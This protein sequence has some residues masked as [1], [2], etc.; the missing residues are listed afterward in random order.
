MKRKQLIFL[1]TGLIGGLICVSFVW[2]GSPWLMI[3]GLTYGVGPLFFVALI[4]GILITGAHRYLRADLLHYLAGLVLCTI[5]Y[6]LAL[7]AFFAVVGISQKVPGVTPSER[8]YNFGL[9][10]WLGLLCAGAVGAIGIS[11][12]NALLT[13]KWSNVL[14]RRLM[15]AGLLTIIVT[16]IVNL[17]FQS[18]WSFLGVLYP[19]GNALFCYLVGAHILRYADKQQRDGIEAD[20]PKN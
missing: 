19:L 5:T 9:D 11:L 7:L 15:V 8:L 13:R 6:F 1:I 4:G 3:L 18:D 12:L 2:S 17:P 10:V 20:E 16:F 14:L